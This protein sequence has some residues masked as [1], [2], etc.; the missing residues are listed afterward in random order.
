MYFWLSVLQTV[1]KQLQKEPISEHLI[2]T[3]PC[4]IVV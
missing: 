2:D 3:R 1:E 4:S